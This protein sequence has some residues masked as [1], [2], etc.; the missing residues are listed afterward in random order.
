M[1]SWLRHEQ[2]T[3][4][5]ALVAALHQSAGSRE[6]KSGDAAERHPTGTDDRGESQGVRCTRRTT[7]HGDRPHFTRGSGQASS[8]SLGRR[9]ATAPCG[10]SGEAPLLAV[11]SLV[12]TALTAP[13]LP[14]AGSLVRKEEEEK[15]KAMK[16]KRS[17]RRSLGRIWT[18]PTAG[19]FGFVESD[20][21]KAALVSELVGDLHFSSASLG[22]L[23]L[24]D[25]VTFTVRRGPLSGSRGL[26]GAAVRGE[27]LS[28]WVPFCGHFLRAPC[29]WQFLP[30]V[31]V[32]SEEY[33]IFI[34]VF[35]APG[36]TVDTCTSVISG[37]LWTN[38]AFSL[39]LYSGHSSCVSFSAPGNLNSIL[40]ALVSGSS[41]LVA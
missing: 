4:R 32:S 29:L 11:P 24:Y 41:C 34:A 26:G 14:R 7:L 21:A 28:S 22:S 16:A 25:H 13:L 6:T 3:V 18:L 35:W 20:D 19:R 12:A 36:S 38:P 15:E 17:P 8:L 2:H 27:G 39:G 9:G 31:P 30:G 1:R 10:P 5:M 33:S 23:R 40:R 37:G